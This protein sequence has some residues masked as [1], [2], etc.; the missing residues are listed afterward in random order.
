[1][2]NVER[3]I[4]EIQGDSEIMR[5]RFTGLLDETANVLERHGF[6]L[7]RAFLLEKQS[8]ANMKRQ[9]TALLQI[10]E[11]LEQYPD[12]NSDRKTARLIIKAVSSLQ[13]EARND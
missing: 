1:M 13:R 8:H 11:K 9:S 12:I 5:T 4:T 10:L 2:D 7:T 6:G 3:V